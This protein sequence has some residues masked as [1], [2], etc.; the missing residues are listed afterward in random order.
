[1]EHAIL[2]SL[3]LRC[4]ASWYAAATA[5]RFGLPFMPNVDSRTKARYVPPWGVF[6]GTPFLV[7]CYPLL[8]VLNL[9]GSPRSRVEYPKYMSVFELFA[10]RLVS[11]R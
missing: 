11:E 3:E 1:M 4:F 8:F 2:Y 7:T 5:A 6:L 9:P 10:G